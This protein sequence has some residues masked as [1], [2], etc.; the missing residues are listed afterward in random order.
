MNVRH[1]LVIGAGQMGSGIAQ[2]F[3]QNGY[4]VVLHDQSRGALEKGL[5]YIQQNLSKDVQKAKINEAEK[6]KT[7]SHLVLHESELATYKAIHEIDLV[8]EAIVENLEVKKNV[9]RMI[10]SLVREDT[11]LATNTSSLSIT[12]IAAV[13]KH[14]HRVMGIHFMNP[15]PVMKLVELIRGLQT[16]DDV[17]QQANT[18]VGTIGKTPIAVED[19]PGFIA[20]RILMPMINEAIFALYEGVATKEA[21]DDIM[22][23]GMNHPMGPLQ[24]ADFIG[25]DTCLAI[26][27]TL[28]V[29]LGDDK[30]RPCPLL[31]KYVQAG[32]LGKKTKK[33]FYEYV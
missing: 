21:I 5:A 26:M 14:P 29:G 9:F 28:H 32:Y 15:V 6:E 2:V 31:R 12:E 30:Y 1:V 16:S 18:V 33:G 10:D 11:I 19:F 13:S 7:L 17:F 8:I 3:A 4:H 20:N 25:L 24:L 22:K 23:L 27:E